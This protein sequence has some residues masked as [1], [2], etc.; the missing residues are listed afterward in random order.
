MTFFG[1]VR[2][3]P[4]F[5]LFTLLSLVYFFSGLRL[6]QSL[7]ERRQEFARNPLQPWKKAWSERAAFLLAVPPGVFVHE[8]FHA[9]AIWGFGGSLDD[10]GFGFYW[11]YVSSADPFTAPQNWFIALAGTLG[12]LLYG[13]VLWLLLR[14]SRS[15]AWRYFGLR[16]LRFHLY[17]ALLYYPL[18]TL[19]TFIGDWRSIYDFGATPILSGA[20]LVVHVTSLA[21]FWW[22]DRHGWY[23]M[24]AFRSDAERQQLQTLQEQ[25]LHNP[26]DQQAQ[27]QMIDALRRKGASNEARQRLRDFLGA[28]PR[29]AHGHLVMA[30]LDAEGKNHLPRSVRS[31]AEEALQL[32][33]PDRDQQGAAHALLGQYYLQ[34]ERNED[35]LRHLDEALALSDGARQLPRTA[36]LHY[37]RALAQRRRGAYQAASDDIEAALRLARETGN[38]RLVAHYENEKKTIAHHRGQI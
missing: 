22:T 12:T 5:L 2:D 38:E 11:G 3:N 23:E 1:A 32:G 36:Q 6:A 8:L 7:W 18:F 27:L 13:F 33:L 20:T 26:Q 28:H 29:S 31:N 34:V 10:A 35:A 4:L 21:L 17:Y 25:A 37:L 9:L 16:V 15:D 30:F 19:F 24:P 14:R